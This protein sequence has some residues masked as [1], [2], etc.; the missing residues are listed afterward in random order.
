M[1]LVAPVRVFSAPPVET[2]EQSNRRCDQMSLENRPAVVPCQRKMA[3]TKGKPVM[4]HHASAAQTASLKG[5]EMR[6]LVEPHDVRACR[7][8]PDLAALRY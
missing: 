7:I 6:F 1:R 4:A 3:I 5:C 8:N 2:G